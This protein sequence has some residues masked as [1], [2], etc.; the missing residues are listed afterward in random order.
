MEDREKQQPQIRCAGLQGV[1]ANLVAADVDVVAF[2][3]QL[4][5]DIECLRNPEARLDVARFVE[6]LELAARA[7]EEPSLGLKLGM[8][9]SIGTFGMLGELSCQAPDLGT[10]GQSVSRFFFMHQERA[11]LDI[12]IEGRDAILSYAIRDARVIDYRHDAEMAMAKALRIA[13]T[14]SGR[15]DWRPRAVCFEHPAP[16]DTSLHREFFGA[17]VYFARPYNA[18]L[19][20][21]DWLSARLPGGDPDSLE[22]LARAAAQ[23]LP[24]VPAE[25]IEGQV[26]RQIVRGLRS[27]MLSAVAVAAALGLS[28]RTLQRRLQESGQ[29]FH[30]LVD[31]TRLEMARRYLAEPHLTL[32]D[33]SAALGYSEPSAFSRAFRRWTGHSPFAERA[34]L[35]RER[36]QWAPPRNVASGFSGQRAH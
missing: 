14:L 12:R 28:E 18:L 33:I 34:S 17:P 36:V 2:C 1:E 19:F 21:T 22:A 4:G 30:A 15:A 27:G 26:R 24:R 9:Q 20:P 16:R 23:Q 35:I 31:N 3:G 7:C 29:T 11:A 32:T 13:R 10:V 6:V 25:D 5:V 8:T